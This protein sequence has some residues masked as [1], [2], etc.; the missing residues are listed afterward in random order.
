M[1]P[2]QVD[3]LTDWHIVPRTEYRC[4][5]SHSAQPVWTFTP[6]RWHPTNNSF[7]TWAH[8]THALRFSCG[9][10]FIQQRYFN[11]GCY[12]NVTLTDMEKWC[13][14]MDSEGVSRNL[15]Q[16]IITFAYRGR[17]KPRKTSVM[18][19]RNL[20]KNRTTYLPNTRI[21]VIWQVGRATF[22]VT[23]PERLDVP[24]AARIARQQ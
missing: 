22:E 7:G 19:V 21:L 23:S 2:H 6:D 11:F 1:P 10:F 17:G 8:P 14:D 18:I 3:W 4:S 9:S 5:L 13:V 24:E 16:Y 15:F 20:F 12:T